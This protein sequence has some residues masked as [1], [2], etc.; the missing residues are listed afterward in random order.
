MMTQSGWHSA[1]D[2]TLLE[3]LGR[4]LRSSEDVPANVLAA[5][6]AVYTWRTVDAELAALAHDS[7]FDA[8]PTA[9]RTES[10]PVRTLTFECDALV[11]ELG[12]GGAGLVGE[13][14]PPRAGTVTVR[15]ASGPAVTVPVDDLG[16]FRVQPA[17]SG[18]FSLHVQTDGNVDVVT[19]WVTL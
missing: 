2:D 12:V 13:L 4:A 11:V 5:A 7:A 15:S 19:D 8:E 10:A 9:F 1:D 18:P 3:E 16:C 6:K 17:P 14:V